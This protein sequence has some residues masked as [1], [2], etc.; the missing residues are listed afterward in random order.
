MELFI[1]KLADEYEKNPDD[2]VDFQFKFGSDTFEIFIDRL[3]RLYHEGM[4]KFIDDITALEDKKF[5]AQ[6]RIDELK[7]L[8][9]GLTEKYF[10]QLQKSF[11]YGRIFLFSS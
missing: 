7:L 6:K 9:E 10:L 2:I 11:G 8:R 5:A 3:Q 4:N 1:C